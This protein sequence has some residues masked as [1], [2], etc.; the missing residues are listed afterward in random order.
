MAAI[1]RP[2]RVPLDSLR[3]GI[4]PRPAGSE[5][6]QVAFL[7][8]C[9]RDLGER[10]LVPILAMPDGTIVDGHC[11]W[12]ALREAGV[13]TALVVA[14]SGKQPPTPEQVARINATQSHVEPAGDTLER[15]RSLVDEHGWTVERLAEAVSRSAGKVQRAIAAWRK[16]PEADKVA[17]RAKPAAERMS[18]DAIEAVAAKITKAKAAEPV[19]AIGRV[20]KPESDEAPLTSRPGGVGK[21]KG[22]SSTD[23]KGRTHRV[24]VRNNTACRT[25]ETVTVT[26]EVPAADWSTLFS[27]TAWTVTPA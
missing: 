22:V 13:E 27:A 9:F 21:S 3:P 11:R 6:A 15:W 14:W 17:D 12:K 1:P 10:Q 19:D 24:K 18:R 26:V 7:A 25:G 5:A 20:K 4:Q 8:A 2:A 16:I 23:P